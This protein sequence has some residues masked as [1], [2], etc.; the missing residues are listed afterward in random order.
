MNAR[1]DGENVL[2]VAA[3]LADVDDLNRRARDV[4]WDESHIGDDLVVLGGRPFA[5]RDQVLAL[6][7]DYQLGL[8]NGTRATV[9]RIDTSRHELVLDTT[10]RERLVVPFAYAE[11]GHLAHGYATTIHKAQGATV[12]RC[13]V[14]A[15]ET[16]TRE[17]AYTALSRG[18][19]GN[20]LFIVA[21]DRRTEDR[22]AAEVD[23]DPLDAVRRAIGRSAAKTM[24]VDQTEPKVPSLEQLRRERDNI[25]A[26]LTGGPVDPSREYRHLTEARDREEDY[27]ENAQW[28]LD[29]AHRSLDRLGPIGRRTRRTERREFERRIAGFETEIARHDQQL[30]EL[31]ARL[32]GRGPEMHTRSSWES[33]HGTEL[34]RLDTLDR[35]INHHQ[36]LEQAASRRAERGTERGLGIEL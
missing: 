9:E 30:T 29:N 24:A 3:R 36:Q 7:N 27:R 33:E 22:H 25:H 8:L 23:P 21:E 6:R 31:E 34:D 17:H 13:Y 1:A 32:A 4:L 18:R 20:E 26:R 10:G 2:M 19:H 5:E 12:D 16:L 15:D 35:Q 11:A 28:R 14:L